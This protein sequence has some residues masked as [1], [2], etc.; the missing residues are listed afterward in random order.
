MLLL[1]DQEEVSFS[2]Q[3]NSN[4]KAIFKTL[5]LV[6]DG[7]SGQKYV[8]PDKRLIIYEFILTKPKAGEAY[9]LVH[10]YL[11][12]LY[13]LLS[14]LKMQFHAHLYGENVWDF[15]LLVYKRTKPLDPD[16]DIRTELVH[17]GEGRGRFFVTLSN[18]DVI[19]QLVRATRN[20]TVDTSQ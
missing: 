8:T 12:N 7:F 13:T 9:E 16:D 10:T 6:L 15:D 1:F 5:V 2:D 11:H 19:I 3:L 17:L 20:T 4:E 18:S 14:E